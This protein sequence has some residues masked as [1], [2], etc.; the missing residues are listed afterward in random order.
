[1]KAVVTFVTIVDIVSAVRK[2]TVMEKCIIC[3][4]VIKGYGN[5]PAPV[6][7]KGKC[8]DACNHLYVIPERIASKLYEMVSK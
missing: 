6:E 8:C 4:T 2:E 3:G 5:N 1:M 7:E